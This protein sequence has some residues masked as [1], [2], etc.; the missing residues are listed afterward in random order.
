MLVNLKMFRSQVKESKAF[1]RQKIPEFR[2]AHS[3]V[4]KETVDIDILITISRSRN[5]DRN[6][7]QPI[8]M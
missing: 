7:M 8:R 2:Q 3:C 5:S 4:K 6:I 1:C